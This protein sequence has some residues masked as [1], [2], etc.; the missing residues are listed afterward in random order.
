MQLSKG[1]APGHPD[2]KELCLRVPARA[3]GRIFRV[4]GAP[5]AGAWPELEQLPHWRQNTEGVRGRAPEHPPA[6]RLPEYLAEH[7]R[8]AP[9]GARAA[10]A[11][12]GTSS[13]LR[14]RA[15]LRRCARA[16]PALLAPARSGMACLP[17]ACVQGLF[18]SSWPRGARPAARLQA[19]QAGRVR[20]SERARSCTQRADAGGL[21]A[22]SAASPAGSA[23]RSFQRGSAAM[24]LLEDMLR[25]NPAQRVTPA[26]ALEHAWFKEARARKHARAPA[27]RLE[28]RA[29]S[30]GPA[31][32]PC[33]RA[34][35]VQG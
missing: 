12:A 26:Q 25:F 28:G 24:G 33:G 22:R 5:D 7:R 11:S 8:V 16:A 30:E 3:R 14:L 1:Q 32:R 13:G 35:A 23:A 4:L 20:H 2:A 21:R 9:G 10:A 31:V 29:C 34:N 17:R 6:S 15:L 19:A 27:G 18:A